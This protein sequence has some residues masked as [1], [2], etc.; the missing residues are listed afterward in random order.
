M[1]PKISL[2]NFL[3]KDILRSRFSTA[4]LE[5]STRSYSKITSS[6]T[7]KAPLEE[8][9]KFDPLMEE[10]T[11]ENENE[12]PNSETDTLFGEPIVEEKTVE[13]ERQ[14]KLRRLLSQGVQRKN[15]AQNTEHAEIPALEETRKEL[16]ELVRR[17]DE[18][19][20]DEK[21]AMRN[22]KRALVRRIS[23]LEA[24]EK[25]R[26][27]KRLK[28]TMDETL[29]NLWALGHEDARKLKIKAEKISKAVAGPEFR[30]RSTLKRN[31]QHTDNDL[32]GEERLRIGKT[33]KRPATKTTG[34]W[35]TTLH[36]YFPDVGGKGTNNIRDALT[37][38]QKLG[39]RRELV[40]LG[41][42]LAKAERKK[43]LL[44]H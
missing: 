10:I 11:T 21:L 8:P 30:Q 28:L 34:H 29:K 41:E 20:A 9:H 36:D 39:N 38:E 25:N 37:P 33:Y 13:E 22:Q 42:A 40:E 19:T 18:A 16:E 4:P 31:R 2:R 3:R 7:T 26:K 17:E 5:R 23:A 1:P 43:K 6:A 44:W 35:G 14:E 27:V 32:D 24:E 12:C 15:V